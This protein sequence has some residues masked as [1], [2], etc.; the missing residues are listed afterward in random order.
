MGGQGRKMTGLRR[1][2]GAMKELSDVFGWFMAFTSIGGLSQVH[3]TNLTASKA[4]W[5]VLFLMGFG[6][7]MF[8]MFQVFSEFL[9]RGI[10]TKVTF[11]TVDKM[12]FPAVTMCNQNR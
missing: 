6:M 5:V 8:G 1:H 2:P 11:G 12:T 4:I 7:T 3:A 10:T 9:A